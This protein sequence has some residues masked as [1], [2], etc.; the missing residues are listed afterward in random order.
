[1]KAILFQS[2]WAI[3]LIATGTFDRLLDWVTVPSLLVSLSCVAGLIRLRFL[4]PEI[5]RPYRVWAYP[6]VPLLFILT[7][8]WILAVNFM[9]DPRDSLMGGGLI[10]L[11]IPLYFYWMR[12]RHGVCSS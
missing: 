10:A 1:V 3:V 5:H 6:W 2:V 7:V 9:E 11:G 12:G 4:R 8:V